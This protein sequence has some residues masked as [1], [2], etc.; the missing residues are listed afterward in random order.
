MPPLLPGAPDAVGLPAIDL[1]GAIRRIGRRSRTTAGYLLPNRGATPQTRT[2]MSDY[3]VRA[4]LDAFMA[5]TATD[6]AL[7]AA[8]TGIEFASPTAA[9]QAE[10]LIRQE[11][12]VADG[13][14]T[15]PTGGDASEYIRDRLRSA[16]YSH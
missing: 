11:L 14:V 5:A 4:R 15:S 3:E 8:K 2:D 12:T 10:G 16:D 7:G 1:S 9:R 13:R 6:S